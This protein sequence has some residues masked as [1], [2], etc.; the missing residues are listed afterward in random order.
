[1]L[2]CHFVFQDWQQ[3]LSKSSSQQ[4]RDSHTHLSVS[5]VVVGADLG[6]VRVTDELAIAEWTVGLTY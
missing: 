5:L 2:L 3:T 1:M 6:Q 4:Q